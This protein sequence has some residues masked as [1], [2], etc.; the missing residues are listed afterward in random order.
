MVRKKSHGILCLDGI[1]NRQWVKPW[2]EK[3]LP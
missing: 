2:Q 3:E 1:R